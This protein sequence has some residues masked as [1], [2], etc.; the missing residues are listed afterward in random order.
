M[1]YKFGV[2]NH[3]H[4]LGWSSKYQW[5]SYPSSYL[6]HLRRTQWPQRHPNLN[7]KSFPPCNFLANTLWYCW[8]KKS[9]TTTWDVTNPV[10]NGIFT[11]STGSPHVWTINSIVGTI[12]VWRDVP[13]LNFGDFVPR[14]LNLH[15]W[16]PP[17]EPRFASIYTFFFTFELILRI[18]AK[19]IKI[20]CG[21]DWG[22]MLLASWWA[23]QVLWVHIGWTH[24]T[25]PAY[26]PTWMVDFYGQ[27]R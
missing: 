12:K 19:G 7:I 24:G 17:E 20:F 15:S 8:W 2:T 18:F 25:F 3:L 27:C 14:I 22:W 1:A 6:S 9:Q 16:C 10:N 5:S 13:C 21:D 4:P 23:A 11:I 26:L